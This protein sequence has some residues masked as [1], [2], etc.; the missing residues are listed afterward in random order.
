[1]PSQPRPQSQW[2]RSFILFSVLACASLAALGF[3]GAFIVRRVSR[4][5]QSPGDGPVATDVRPNV[6]LPAVTAGWDNVTANLLS[7]FDSVDVIAL[8]EGLGRKMD[9]ELRLRLIRHPDF[10]FRAHLIV[11]EFGNSLYQS[12]LDKY[13]YGDDV[14][15]EALENVWWH[16][17]PV[18]AEFFAAV[19]EVNRKLPPDRRVRVVAGDVPIDWDKVKTKADL[20]PFLLRRGFPVS[21][22]RVAVPRG[23]KAL[24]IYTSRY[25]KRPVFPLEAASEQPMADVPADAPLPTTAPPMFKALQVAGPGRVFVVETVAGLNLFEKT[26]QFGELPAL[27]PLTG[28][29]SAVGSGLGDEADACVYFGNTQEANATVPP[30]AAT[31]HGTAL[32]AELGRRQKI[33]ESAQSN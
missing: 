23:E 4:S 8:G 32:G 27:V 21:L 6:A 19:R 16:D 12:T 11:V 2:L 33:M 17:S 31:W 29:H 3:L 18:Y 24:V 26:I 1:M 20:V 14:P 9:S 22:S 28:I 30:D 15:M 10:P 13:V 7:A 25:L 5:L